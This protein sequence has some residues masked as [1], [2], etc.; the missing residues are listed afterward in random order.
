[1]TSRIQSTRIVL[2]Q[3][4][5]GAPDSSTFRFETVDLPAPADGELLVRHKYV[6]LDPY[7]RG[8]M[9]AAKSYA[10]PT[11]VGEVLPAETVSE[12]VESRH[13]GFEPGQMVTTYG[14]WQSAAVVRGDHVRPVPDNGLSDSTALGVLGMPGFTAYSG[15]R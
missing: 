9:S 7:M 15:L 13:P 1:M 2:A 6:S 8:R 14:G 3:R 4:P 10:A 12:V 5:H 11:P